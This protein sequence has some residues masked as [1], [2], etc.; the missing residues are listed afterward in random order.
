MLPYLSTHVSFTKFIFISLIIKQMNDLISRFTSRKFL[1]AIAASI[2]AYVTASQD[3]VFTQP[4]IML[5]IAPIVAFIA[6]EGAAD[7][8]TRYTNIPPVDDEPTR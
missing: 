4:E 1:G 3:G 7:A 5:I 8:V 2:T 6:A